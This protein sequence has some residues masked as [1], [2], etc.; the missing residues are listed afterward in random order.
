MHVK[1]SSMSKKKKTHHSRNKEA[2]ILK[3]VAAPYRTTATK[4]FYPLQTPEDQGWEEFR[5]QCRR[6]ME[7]PLALRIKYGFG[8][9]IKRASNVQCVRAFKTMADY[10]AWCEANLPA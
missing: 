1:F 6:Q 4:E 7:R 10:R 2:N 5:D 9:P 8:R 3:E